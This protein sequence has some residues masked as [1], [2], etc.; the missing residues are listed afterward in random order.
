MKYKSIAL[1]IGEEI[2]FDESKDIALKATYQFETEKKEAAIKALH[3][4]NKIA[5]LESKKKTTTLYLVLLF[6]TGIA[7]TSY[8]L[9]SRYK[10]KKKNELLE[11]NGSK[12]IEFKEQ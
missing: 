8:V 11:N 1:D 10:E 6:F 2:Y 3:Q 12:E 9:F 4:K 5:E 7:T